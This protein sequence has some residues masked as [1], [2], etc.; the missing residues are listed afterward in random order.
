MT[1]AV[2]NPGPRMRQTKKC[3]GVKP[4]KGICFS[5]EAVQSIF[6]HDILMTRTTRKRSIIF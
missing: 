6:F 5:A 3:D 1:C 2:G 4:A